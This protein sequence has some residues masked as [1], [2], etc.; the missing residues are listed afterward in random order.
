MCDLVRPKDPIV[1]IANYMLMN[2]ES[3]KNLG[4]IIKENNY[5][6]PEEKFESDEIVYTQEERDEMNEEENKVK[7]EEEEM[8][9]LEDEK[10]KE[11]EEKK[12][13]EEEERKK[14]EEE[15]GGKKSKRVTRSNFNKKKK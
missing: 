5:N 13:K 12:R 10:R 7:E 9:R 15:S 6:Q 1:F 2:K 4:N 3:V 14:K 8:E 11:E